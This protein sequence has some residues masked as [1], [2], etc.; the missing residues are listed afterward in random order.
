MIVIRNII[1]TFLLL[2]SLLGQS[3]NIVPNPSFESMS[4]DCEVMNPEFMC[5][6]GWSDYLNLDA[7]NTPDIGY[8]GAVFFPPSTIDA[9]D[10]NQYLNLECSTGNPEYAQ[11]DLTEP[12]QAG[13][14]YCVSFYASHSQESP[15]VAPSLGVYFSGTPLL[16]SP[17]ELGLEAHV[18]GPINFDPTAWTLISGNYLAQGGENILVVGGFENTG[19]M[20][21]PYMYIDMLSVVAM[22][23]LNLSDGDLC[24]GPIVLDASA[25]GASYQWST[26]ETTSAI[27]ANTESEITVS[28][29]I[30]ACVQ[31]ATV[32]IEACDIVI[33][34]PDDDPID[35]PDDEPVDDPTDVP[36]DN[37]ESAAVDLLF[38]APNT[39]TP[40]GD[41]LNDV[42]GIVGPTTDSFE[43]Q[44]FDRWG[45]VIFSSTDINE[46]W[47]ANHLGGDYFVQDGIYV[48][49]FTAVEG[50]RVFE[51]KGHVLVVR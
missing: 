20:P 13:V 36:V 46:R 1:F 8:E 27:T 26:G 31:Q 40:D 5:S 15:E 23:E 7:V 42:F 33:D 49:Q 14:S 3:Q 37:D 34:D 4:A 48:Y 21:F 28:R 12:M 9:F 16:D 51:G 35:N 18:Q 19:T 29:T 50:T 47:T 22:P 17:F 6:V 25:P 10:G 30:G 45:E 43:L 41:G 38:F 32:T 24:D 39:F 11:I 2:F 44:I